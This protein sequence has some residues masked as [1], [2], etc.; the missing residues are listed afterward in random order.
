MHPGE[1]SPWD[2]EDKSS[3]APIEA[4]TVLSIGIVRREL[5]WRSTFAYLIGVCGSAV[6]LGLLTDWV[7]STWEISIKAQSGEDAELFPGWVSMTALAFLVL[8]T[9]KVVSAKFKIASRT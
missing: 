4:V 2:E 8:M 6:I 5:G 1:P 3:T 7:I 9:A